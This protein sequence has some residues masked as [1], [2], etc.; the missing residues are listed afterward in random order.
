MEVSGKFHAPAALLPWKCT[1]CHFER[2]LSRPQSPS[3]HGVEEKNSQ[4]FLE[5]EVRSSRT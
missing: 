5:I 4:L 3:G 2:R 1:R